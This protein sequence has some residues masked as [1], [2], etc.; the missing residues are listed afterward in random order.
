MRYLPLRYGSSHRE[1]RQALLGASG[2]IAEG[3]L[4]L[5]QRGGRALTVVGVT[6]TFA[7]SYAGYDASDPSERILLATGRTAFI[8]GSG[9]AGGLM[10]GKIC[11]P[12][13]PICSISA[14]AIGGLAGGLAG[15]WVWENADQHWQTS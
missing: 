10:V 6:I 7:D 11:G 13:A 5:A 8:S 4:A 1:I 2:S 3:R 12:G 15:E 14:G 9:V